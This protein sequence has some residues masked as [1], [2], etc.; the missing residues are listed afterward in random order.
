VSAGQPH[1]TAVSL[2]FRLAPDTR[3]AGGADEPGPVPPPYRLGWVIYA[4]GSPLLT[5]D[6]R[7]PADVEDAS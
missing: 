6:C 2:L 4:G 5:L 3:E 1:D 7:L